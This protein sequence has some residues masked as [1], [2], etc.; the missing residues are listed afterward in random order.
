VLLLPAVMARLSG[1]RSL[2]AFIM[3]AFAT[4]PLIEVTATIPPPRDLLSE[5]FVLV[6]SLK[7]GPVVVEDGQLF[8]Q[9]WFYLPEPLK[10]NMIFLVDSEASVK[11]Q[12]FTTSAIDAALSS[13]RLSFPIRVLDYRTFATTGKEFRLLQNPLRP[14]WLLD[15]IAADGGSEVIDRYTNLRQLYRIRIK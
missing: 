13:V 9:M 15:K 12:V 11:Y 10:S 5:E 1:G 4:L 14:G 3:L 7:Q 6:E 2:P 8:M